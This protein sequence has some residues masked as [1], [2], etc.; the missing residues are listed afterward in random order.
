MAAYQVMGADNDYEDA[1]YLWRRIVKAGKLELTK[2]ELLQITRGRF[3]KTE[4]MEPAIQ[5]L[6]DMNYI[7]RENRK[8]GGRPGEL[9]LV[10]PEQ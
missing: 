1:K 6:I 9:I 5:T 8:T 4:H 2:N 7:R 3:K 10:N